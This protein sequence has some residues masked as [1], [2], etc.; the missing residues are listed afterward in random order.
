MYGNGAICADRQTIDYLFEI[1]AVVLA[2]PLGKV[3]SRG[4]SAGHFTRCFD[5][6]GIV[7]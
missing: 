4:R 7:M 1:G 5:A 2:V 3:Q 6:G